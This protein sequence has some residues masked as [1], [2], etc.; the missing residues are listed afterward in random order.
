MTEPTSNGIT[1]LPVAQEKEYLM[2]NELTTSNYDNMSI[3]EMMGITTSGGGGGPAVARVRQIQKT[4]MGEIE[5]AGK[6]IKTEV[7]GVGVYGIT[8]PDGTEVV[9]ESVDIRVFAVRQQFQRWDAE[10]NMTQK[11]VMATTLNQDLKDTTGR[12]NLGRPSGY[13]QDFNALPESTKEL[14]R[15]ITRVRIVMGLISVEK[16]MNDKGEPLDIEVKDV[17]FV[18]E[19]K[20]RDSLK[21]L[22]DAFAAFKRKNVLPI[23]G[24]ITLDYEAKT[25]PTGVNYGVIVATAGGTV[26]L[27]SE[28]QTM[29]RNFMDYIEYVNGYVMRKWSEANVEGISDDDAALVAGLVDIEGSDE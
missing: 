3:E 13:V 14:M 28:D 6:K 23:M 7:V 19:V 27:S 20:N 29:L 21:S 15:S 1:M 18:L 10:A 22:D 8:L 2:S 24:T 25:T 5:V 16:P 26:E 12:F 11:T 17:P 9:A 4:T